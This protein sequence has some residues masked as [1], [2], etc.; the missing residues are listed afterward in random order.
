MGFK[1]IFFA[2]YAILEGFRG[3]GQRDLPPLILCVLQA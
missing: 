3:D 1:I 2:A